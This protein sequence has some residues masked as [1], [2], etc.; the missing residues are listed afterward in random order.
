MA[1]TEDIAAFMDTDTGFAENATIGAATVPLI[2][3]LAYLDALGIVSAAQ[4][5]ALAASAD[6]SAVSVGTTVTVRSVAYTVAEI[7]PD[8]AG[9]T[10][11]MLKT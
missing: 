9:M 7:Q 6:V 1:F 3:D 11:L 10:R 2:F 5:V 8:G 4:P